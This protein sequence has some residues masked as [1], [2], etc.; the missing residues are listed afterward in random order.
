MKLFRL[1]DFIVGRRDY[2][3]GEKSRKI[4]DFFPWAAFPLCTWFTG[5]LIYEP[6]PLAVLY[7]WGVSCSL[8]TRPNEGRQ[9]GIALN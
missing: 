2:F 8:V 3:L 4:R 9:N 5:S 7:S 6:K 1:R